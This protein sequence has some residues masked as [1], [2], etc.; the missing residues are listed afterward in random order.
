MRRQVQIQG[1]LMLQT[2]AQY[3]RLNFWGWLLSCFLLS[4]GFFSAAATIG[5]LIQKAAMREWL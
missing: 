4:E 3:L 2:E 5:L 1:Q